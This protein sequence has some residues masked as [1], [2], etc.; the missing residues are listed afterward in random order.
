MPTPKMILFC[1]PF[2]GGSAVSY[3]RW[4]GLLDKQIELVP[5]ELPGR[6]KRYR[7]PLYEDFNEVV[8][9]LYKSLRQSIDSRPYAI[10]GHSMGSLLAYELSHQ[11][12]SMEHPPLGHLFLSGRDAPHNPIQPD[13]LFSGL[14]NVKLIE[15]IKQMGIASS[16][17]FQSQ[18]LLDMFIPVLRADFKVVENYRFEEK[19]RRLNCNLTVLNGEDDPI[20]KHDMNEWAQYT[21]GQCRT[22]KFP[23]GHFFIHQHME[24][25]V[26]LINETLLPER[27]SD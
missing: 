23:G 7:E 4:K 22:F 12:Q 5:L 20:I 17:I 25:I 24:R 27:I 19:P 15:T 21:N 1:I 9:D 11:V 10:Y 8:T 2:A 13:Q 18:E 3:F 16:E 14:P 6:G 26:E